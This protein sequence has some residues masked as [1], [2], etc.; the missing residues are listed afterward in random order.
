MEKHGKSE[1]PSRS[2]ANWRR[3]RIPSRSK[4]TMAT[5]ARGLRGGHSTSRGGQRRHDH[6][7]HYFML[8]DRSGFTSRRG[9]GRQHNLFP[10]ALQLL[11]RSG[12]CNSGRTSGDRADSLLVALPLFPFIAISIS[13]PNCS[14]GYHF[15]C[16]IFMLKSKLERLKGVFLASG[17]L[18]LGEGTARICAML[19]LVLVSRVYGASTLGSL[20]LAQTLA[21]YIS[22]ALDA[23]SRHIGA[24]LLAT[25]PDHVQWIQYRI[26]KR[27]ELL[28][29]VAIPVGV[30]YARFGPI[31][32]DARNLISVYI[33]LMAP[34]CFS[35]DWVLW[36]SNR[37]GSLSVSRALMSTLP[38]AAL[39]FCVLSGLDPNWAIPISA[40]IGYGVPA[41]L[42]GGAA[43]ASPTVQTPQL[44][45]VQSK[46]DRKPDGKRYS[47]SASLS[48]ATKPSIISIHLCWEG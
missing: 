48:L 33:L 1:P 18:A 44:R 46:S 8:F 37:Y 29:L 5:D 16:G 27:R 40:G 34:Y 42:P 28:A 35:L 20:A 21:I 15:M 41:P 32:G 30:L 13:E 9:S 43:S 10:S 39:G 17:K 38:L 31:P 3:S 22:L 26:Q 14:S 19:T 47:F 24:R 6:M 12:C 36:G 7:L 23:G 4:N 2:I 45:I 25:H 11:S